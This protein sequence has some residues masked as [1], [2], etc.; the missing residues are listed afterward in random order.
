MYL[1]VVIAIFPS[2]LLHFSLL[3]CDIS[4]AQFLTVSVLLGIRYF[5]RRL[6]VYDP[7]KR[8]SAAEA[9]E[10]RW[11]NDEPLPTPPEMFPTWPAKSELCKAVSRSPPKPISPKQVKFCICV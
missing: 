10:H 6:L 1:L 9:L 11:F 4:L 8:L 3:G 7:A 5:S 2:F